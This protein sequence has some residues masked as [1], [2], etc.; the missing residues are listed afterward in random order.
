MTEDWTNA[1]FER[2]ERVVR[3][4]VADETVLVPVASGGAADLEYLYRMNRTGAAVWDALDGRKTGGE[5]V[6]AIAAA[7]DLARPGS[8]E[9]TPQEIAED[10]RSFLV[11][12]EESKLVRRRVG[13]AMK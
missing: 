12:L 2:N 3:R 7:F 13:R 8:P 1:V 6:S 5:I 4:D 11:D 9:V 10:V